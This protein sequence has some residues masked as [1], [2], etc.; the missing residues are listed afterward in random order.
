MW[1]YPVAI[2]ADKHMHF[3]RPKFLNSLPPSPDHPLSSFFLSKI[4]TVQDRRQETTCVVPAWHGGTQKF[5]GKEDQKKQFCR[6]TLSCYWNQAGH[7]AQL[8]LKPCPVKGRRGRLTCIQFLVLSSFQY[9]SRPTVQVIDCYPQNPDRKHS[10]SNASET[11]QYT[12]ISF[13]HLGPR[14]IGRF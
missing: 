7:V 14:E 4:R 5:F 8:D 13:L 2:T 10:E 11:I 9:F 3:E 1:R 12:W 6:K